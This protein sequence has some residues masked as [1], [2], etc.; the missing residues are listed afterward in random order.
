[1]DQTLAQA[2]IFH[3]LQPEEISELTRR[4][5]IVDS[6]PGHVFF[7]EGDLGSWMYIVVSGKVKIGCRASDGRQKLFSILGPSEMFGELSALDPGARTCTATALTHVRAAVMQ[8]DEILTLIARRPEVAHRLMRILARRLRRTDDDQS[9]LIFVDV[10][11]RVALQLLRLAQ[12][13]GVQDGDAMKVTHDLTQEEL[14]QL[15]G[16][17][18]ETVNKALG[19]FVARGWITLKGKT[20]LIANSERLAARACETPSEPAVTDTGIVSDARSVVMKRFDI[21]DAQAAAL[22]TKL[23]R[24]SNTPLRDVAANI[25][26]GGLTSNTV[27]SAALS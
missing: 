17:T 22:L 20:V 19:D 5:N 26:A 1:M 2:A 4:L 14:A 23:S 6:A 8:R 9:H 13:F 10:A 27:G 21:D 11:G 25:L 12:R 16:A 15:V 3:G 24:T 7:T 18:R